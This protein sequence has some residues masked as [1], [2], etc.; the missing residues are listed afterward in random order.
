[1]NPK[2]SGKT[3][4]NWYIHFP[5]LSKGPAWFSPKHLETLQTRGLF[6]VNLNAKSGCGHGASLGHHWM[7]WCHWSEEWTGLPKRGELEAGGSDAPGCR[8]GQRLCRETSGAQMVQHPGGHP[9]RSWGGVNVRFAW[10]VQSWGHMSK[11]TLKTKPE[12]DGWRSHVYCSSCSVDIYG[13]VFSIWVWRVKVY[14]APQSIC[15]VN[16]QNRQK[17]FMCFIFDP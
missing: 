11:E 15:T 8:E 17:Q 3:I 10:P 12:F 5:D 6:G 9:D 1:M 16:T 4:I 7:R 14:S 13:L 2:C